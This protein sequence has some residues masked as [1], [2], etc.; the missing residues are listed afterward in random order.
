MSNHHWKQRGG[1]CK[2]FIGSSG[3]ETVSKPSGFGGRAPGKRVLEG[4]EGNGRQQYRAYG[5]GGEVARVLPGG[6]NCMSGWQ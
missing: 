4:I 2:L 1:D 5:R 6:G 3:K